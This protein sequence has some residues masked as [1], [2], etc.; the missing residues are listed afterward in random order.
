LLF[1]R[2]EKSRAAFYPI[3]LDLVADAREAEIERLVAT[4]AT[5]DRG[6]S[7]ALRTWTVMRDPEG[8]PFWVG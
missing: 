1:Q 6:K 3:H 2:R 7:G 4:G 5:V 8:N